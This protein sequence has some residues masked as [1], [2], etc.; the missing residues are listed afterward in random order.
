MLLMLLKNG[1][2]ILKVFIYINNI[3]Y[4]IKAK[5]YYERG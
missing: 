4:F 2:I 1:M 3:A 5:A